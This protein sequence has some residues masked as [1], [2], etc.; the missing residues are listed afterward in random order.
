MSWLG[1]RAPEGHV[2]CL[3]DVGCL[4]A[5]ARF[6]GALIGASLLDLDRAATDCGGWSETR[7]SRTLRHS[8]TKSQ[9]TQ[10]SSTSRT[11]GLSR[12]NSVVLRAFMARMFLPAYL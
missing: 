12:C 8:S 1:C 3:A 5:C 9:T 11:T 2:S 6:S 4:P 10:N 7:C